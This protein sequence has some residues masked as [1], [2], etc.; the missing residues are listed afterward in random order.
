MQDRIIK[1]G[2]LMLYQPW[3]RVGDKPVNVVQRGN[4]EARLLPQQ[5]GGICK[6]SLK[7]V[8]GG[9]RQFSNPR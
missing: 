1:V 3:G 7:V 9:E 6:N 8:I 2:K 4:N 5:H